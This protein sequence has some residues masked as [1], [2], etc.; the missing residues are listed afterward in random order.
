MRQAEQQKAWLILR[1]EAAPRLSTMIAELESL[2]GGVKPSALPPGPEGLKLLLSRCSTLQLKTLRCRAIDWARGEKKGMRPPS[3]LDEIL[4][5]WDKTHRLIRPATIEWIRADAEN[6]EADEV[7]AKYMRYLEVL[8]ELVVLSSDKSIIDSLETSLEQILDRS[9]DFAEEVSAYRRATAELLRWERRTALAQARSHTENYAPMKK[10]W[11]EAAQAKRGS[12]GLVPRRARRVAQAELRG[13]MPQI[14]SAMATDLLKKQVQLHSLVGLPTSKPMVASKY[15]QRVYG[16]FSL[17]EQ[18]A[19]AVNL[20]RV[21]LL[22]DEQSPPLTLETAVAL[23][24]GRRGDFELAGCTIERLKLE[25]LI[26]RFAE[27]KESAQRIVPIGPLPSE[28]LGN[29][30][31]RQVLLRLSVRPDWLQNEYFFV[32][33]TNQVT[34]N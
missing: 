23:D 18:V 27:L 3:E 22:V 10:V 20:L 32:D 7:R 9:P 4:K 6:T 8:S 34:E 14:L 26:Y 25:P 15:D 24:R 33:L 31:V 13:S 21:K 29:E 28:S 11:L 12:P 2:M 19:D 1:Q 16:T 5:Q 30:P 17:P